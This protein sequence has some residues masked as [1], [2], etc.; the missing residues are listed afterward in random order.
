MRK[1]NSKCIRKE[2]AK[3]QYVDFIVKI[4][5]ENPETNPVGGGVW[6]PIK[7][8]QGWGMLRPKL[9]VCG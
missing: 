7:D 8:V 2:K 6:K 3:G 5:E 4:L 1:V 9:D